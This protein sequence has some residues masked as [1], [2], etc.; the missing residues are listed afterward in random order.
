MG[1]QKS[2]EFLKQ[3]PVTEKERYESIPT[4]VDSIKGLLI[5]F[6]R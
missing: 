2:S 6:L 3:S 1:D 5:D 4:L